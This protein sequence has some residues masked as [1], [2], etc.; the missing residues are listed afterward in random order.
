MSMRSLTTE[1]HE[2]ARQWW[3][4]HHKLPDRSLM[5]AFE[6]PARGWGFEDG[7]GELIAM[8]FAYYDPDSA[9]GIVCYPVTSPTAGYGIRTHRALIRLISDVVDELRKLGARRIFGSTQVPA[10]A[11]SYLH[12][13]FIRA[14]ESHEFVYKG[15]LS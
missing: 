8:I 4:D 6:W 1:D 12:N 7:Q 10:V 15:D 11:D 3:T 14:Y 13:N 9:C 5:D 2:T